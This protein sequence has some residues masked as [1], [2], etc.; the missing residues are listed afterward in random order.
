MT[1]PRCPE[2]GK[3]PVAADDYLCLSCRI[4]NDTGLSIGRRV[5][6][7]GQMY[8]PNILGCTVEKSHDDEHGRSAMNRGILLKV[9]TA[10]SHMTFIWTNEKTFIC[11]GCGETAINHQEL[12]DGV[13]AFCL[14]VVIPAW[15]KVVL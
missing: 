5:I 14:K 1:R 4:A 12:D 10:F 15:G 11:S 3:E 6:Y 13:C 2:C 9:P 7:H 8:K